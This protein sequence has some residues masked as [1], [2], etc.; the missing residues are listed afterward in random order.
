MSKQ[1]VSLDQ[2]LSYLQF[3]NKDSEAFTQKD[4]K[5]P[6]AAS[7]QKVAPVVLRKPVE[8]IKLNEKNEDYT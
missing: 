1:F 5:L 8:P 6:Q 2:A 7:N 4:F 3:I